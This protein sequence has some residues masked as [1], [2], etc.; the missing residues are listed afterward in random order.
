MNAEIDRL[1]LKGE[2]EKEGE[3]RV[4]EKKNIWKGK[5]INLA[6]STSLF[7]NQISP[8]QQL[9]RLPHRILFFTT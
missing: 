2:N 8:P 5:Q 6:G 1:Y 3:K 4:T 7:Y 9:L